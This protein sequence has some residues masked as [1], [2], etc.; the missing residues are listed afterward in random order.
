MKLYTDEVYNR[1]E[2]KGFADLLDL[3]R[4]ISDF[5]INNGQ[6]IYKIGEHYYRM[7]AI[8]VARGEVRLIEVDKEGTYLYDEEGKTLKRK[9]PI[10]KFEDMAQIEK[11]LTDDC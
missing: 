1:L 2:E 8:D 5:L 4:Y 11:V 9:M 7:P 6:I 10:A 3:Q